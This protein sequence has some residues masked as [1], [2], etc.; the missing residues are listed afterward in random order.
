MPY[1]FYYGTGEAGEISG[2]IDGYLDGFL[3]EK[4]IPCENKIIMQTQ[5]FRVHEIYQ[6][7][8]KGT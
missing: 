2:L 3:G 4:E 1:V 6:A 7:S 5:T 8:H